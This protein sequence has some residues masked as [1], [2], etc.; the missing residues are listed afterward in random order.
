[1]FPK[2]NTG[3]SS[4][5]LRDREDVSTGEKKSRKG[6]K[7]KFTIRFAKRRY[8]GDLSMLR[9]G[10]EYVNTWEEPSLRKRGDPMC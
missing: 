7:G 5:P 9:R 6:K 2:T 1:M 8:K 10:T 3:G 4:P